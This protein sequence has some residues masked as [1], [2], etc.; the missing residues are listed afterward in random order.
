MRKILLGLAA[1]AVVATP[2]AMAASANANVAVTDGVGFVGKGDVQTALGYHNDS[3]TQ[4]AFKAGK[5]AFVGTFNT[6]KDTSWQCTDGTV[7][8]HYFNT[9]S[10]NQYTAKANTNNAGKLTFGWNLDGSIASYGPT[11]GFT[12]GDDGTG[13]FPTYSCAGNGSTIF[14]TMHVD[15]SHFVGDLSVTN[16]AKTVALPNTPIV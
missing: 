4:A 1:T 7:K 9:T 2:L 16:G 6:V 15:Q 3:E 10:V 13:R 5:I 11:T 8:H 12:T 14:S